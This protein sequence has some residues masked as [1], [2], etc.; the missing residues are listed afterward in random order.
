MIKVFFI[1]CTN[2]SA[3]AGPMIASFGMHAGEWC[4]VGVREVRHGAWCKQSHGASD[5]FVE[6]T[7]RHGVVESESKSELCAF[8]G[9]VDA[10]LD[11]KAMKGTFYDN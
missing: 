2:L 5:V 1:L 8:Q 3:S 6:V 7:M 4:I 10:N 9:D 11:G